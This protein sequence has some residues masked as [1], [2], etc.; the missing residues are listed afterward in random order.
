MLFPD[1]AQSISGFILNYLPLNT[2][3][4]G[5]AAALMASIATLV[6]ACPCALGLATPTALMVG[7]GIGA[8]RGVLI[9]NGEALQTMKDVRAVI[10]DKTGTLTHGKPELVDIV[11]NGI[12]PDQ[13]LSIAASLDAGSSHPLALALIRAAASKSLPVSKITDYGYHSGK[14]SRASID[15]KY[16]RVGSADFIREADLDPSSLPVSTTAAY[17]SQVFLADESHVIASFYIADSLRAEAG[18]VVAKLRSMGIEPIMLS[19]DKQETAQA[20][21]DQVGI[22]RFFAQALPE[23]KASLVKALQKEY[24]RVAMVGD[25]IN[26]APALKTADIG[27]AMGQGTDIAIEAA[28]ITVV[29]DDLRSLPLAV[30]LSIQTFRK[31]R[32]NLFWA[33]F[34]NLIA[35]PLAV[36]GILH[37]IIAE[38]AMASSSVTVVTNANLLR[39]K[40]KD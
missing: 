28:D 19:G 37:P 39:R 30:E 26:D 16:F 25:G 2:P 11:T 6:I 17:A 9:R 8:K 24:G 34:Y 5:L 36:L 27:I 38:I 18:E 4:T 1:L 10:F 40:I 15:G 7:S 20:I 31:I 22:T 13:A 23:Q 14:G 12:D 32:Q 29:R 35:I 3:K 21:A 33:F